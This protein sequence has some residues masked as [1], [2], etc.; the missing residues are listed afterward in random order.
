MVVMM[1][2]VRSKKIMAVIGDQWPGRIIYGGGVFG[3]FKLRIRNSEQRE[4]EVHEKGR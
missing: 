1:M 3:G 2:Q 4:H